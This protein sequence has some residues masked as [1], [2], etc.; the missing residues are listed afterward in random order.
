MCCVGGREALNRCFILRSI[1]I[2]L[3]LHSLSSLFTSRAPMSDYP[4]WADKTPSR[5]LPAAN[6]TNLHFTTVALSS[7]SQL[8]RSNDG[9]ALVKKLPSSNLRL[10]NC[11]QNLPWKMD[12]PSAPM[13]TPQLLAKEYSDE[14]M[15]LPMPNPPQYLTPQHLPVQAQQQPQYQQQQEYSANYPAA[16]PPPYSISQN[17]PLSH[18]TGFQ[19]NNSPYQATSTVLPTYQPIV[20]RANRCVNYVIFFAIFL[21]VYFVLR[22]VIAI[23]HA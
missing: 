4:F 7:H 12:Q 19:V 3:S 20:A 8:F 11:P 15:T 9:F 2:C 18:H 10:L 17:M 22:L 14:K 23:S 16:A 6:E 5:A 13:Q 1:V 21:F